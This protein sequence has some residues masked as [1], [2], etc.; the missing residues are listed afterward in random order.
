M[1][2]FSKHAQGIAA[3][4]AYLG[5]A[6]PVITWG[7]AGQAQTIK[8]LPGSVVRR[9]DLGPGGFKLEADLQFTALAADVQD[10][11]PT[12]KSLIQYDG[13]TYEVQAIHKLSG[14][15]VWRYQCDAA[16]EGA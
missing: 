13:E 16:D 14:D 9:K 11:G 6:C 5:A 3:F 12:L 2:P 4:Q 1:D 8:V 10:A 7:V 15:T